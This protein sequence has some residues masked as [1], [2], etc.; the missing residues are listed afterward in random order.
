MEKVGFFFL[1]FL[2]F[3]LSYLHLL[4]SYTFMESKTWKVFEISGNTH[5]ILSSN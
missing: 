4:A 5:L 2:P 3:F 1:L